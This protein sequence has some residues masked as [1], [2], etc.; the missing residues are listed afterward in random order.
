MRHGLGHS[1]DFV[2]ELADDAGDFIGGAGGTH[3]E[4]AHFIRHHGEAASGLAGAGRF[5]RGIQRQH[6]G[7]SG[8]GMNRVDDGV[9]L[10]CG[11]GQFMHFLR[12]TI[13]F[14]H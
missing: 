13:H 4:I 14:I 1:L 10:L 2:I 3:G 6:I 12:R 11:L 5:D 8:N 7:L 9:N